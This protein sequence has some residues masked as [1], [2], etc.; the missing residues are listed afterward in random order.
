MK[1]SK[2]KAQRLKEKSRWSKT[3]EVSKTQSEK[4]VK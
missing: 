4:E 3:K 2:F 1:S